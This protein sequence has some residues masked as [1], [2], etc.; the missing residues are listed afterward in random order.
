MASQ[1]PSS[2]SRYTL[3]LPTD[4]LAPEE[5]PTSFNSRLDDGGN[6][7]RAT[8]DCKVYKPEEKKCADN[9]NPLDISDVCTLKVPPQHHEFSL[10]IGSNCDGQMEETTSRALDS[11]TKKLETLSDLVSAEAKNHE[12]ISLEKGK[13]GPPNPN[14]NLETQ[15]VT[16]SNSRSTPV[17]ALK[18][19]DIFC[20]NGIYPFS[21]A[22]L[23]KVNSLTGRHHPNDSV[24]QEVRHERAEP[25]QSV[26][27]H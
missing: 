13:E 9:Q 16:S 5:F 18:D 12:F 19:S 8:G 15:S 26:S 24:V 2:V 21:A 25:Q 14:S 11:Q 3:Q 27:G 7:P 17:Q 23:A 6:C 10:K 4:N 1:S 20:K 22:C